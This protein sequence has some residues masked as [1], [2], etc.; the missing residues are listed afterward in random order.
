VRNRLIEE[1][2]DELDVILHIIEVTRNQIEIYFN[3]DGYSFSFQNSSLIFEHGH[4]A[5]D[6]STFG[7][8]MPTIIEQF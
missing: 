8:H 5:N 2:L 6:G 7:S 4:A 3:K 1:L